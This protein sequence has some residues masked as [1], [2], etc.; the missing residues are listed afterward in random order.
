VAARELGLSDRARRGNHDL[1]EM[2]AE[3]KE[4]NAAMLPPY[5][6]VPAGAKVN[7]P[8]DRTYVTPRRMTLGE[9]AAQETGDRGNAPALLDL[10]DKRLK[11]PTQLPAGTMVKIPQRNIPALA[12]F[13]ALAAVLALVGLG[14]S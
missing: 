9:L 1:K 7:L 8:E 10:N 2:V 6:E 13:A 4:I 3:M 12:V 14:G 5:T 11:L